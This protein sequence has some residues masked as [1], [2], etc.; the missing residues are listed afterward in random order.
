M[1]DSNFLHD[2]VEE[3]IRNRKIIESA[4]TLELINYQIA[5]LSRIKE[6]VE[7]KLCELLMHTDDGSK[8]YIVDRY[9]ITLTSGYIYSLDKE[10]YERIKL[11]IPVSVN[12]VKEKVSYEIDKKQIKQMER[13]A[14]P[15]ELMLLQQFISKKPKKL[16]CKITAGI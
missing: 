5:E 2:D 7:S 3:T 12:P 4:K 15:E 9:K 16:H 10:N 1:L 14:K 6:E 13:F 11:N 8:S